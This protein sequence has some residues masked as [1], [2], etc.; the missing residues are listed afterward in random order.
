MPFITTLTPLR[1][2]QANSFT[3]PSCKHCLVKLDSEYQP[4]SVVCPRCHAVYAARDA[5]RRYRLQLLAS[6]PNGAVRKLTIFGA[7]LDP[8]FGLS[9]S[10]FET[11]LQAPTAVPPQL[12]LSALHHVL[13]GSRLWASIP[14]RYTVQS[15]QTSEMVE[16]VLQRADSVESL[17]KELKGSSTVEKVELRPDTIISNVKPMLGL[18]STVVSILNSRDFYKVKKD[19]H[20]VPSPAVDL[21]ETE[22]W[23][24]IPLAQCNSPAQGGFWMDEGAQFLFEEI[25]LTEFLDASAEAG[26]PAVAKSPSVTHI[27]HHTRNDESPLDGGLGD[28]IEDLFQ[29]LALDDWSDEDYVIKS[30]PAAPAAQTHDNN[31]G[32][33]KT[34]HSECEDADRDDE[35]DT[36]VE[37]LFKDLVLDDLS[38]DD[39]GLK[40][41]QPDYAART[42]DTP[43]GRGITDHCEG[44]HIH[45]DDEYDSLDTSFDDVELIE[46]LE[47][48]ALSAEAG[49]R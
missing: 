26:T 37:E 16:Q 46:L 32:N 40:R 1:I 6:C 47:N 7:G 11:Y 5:P 49:E 35:Y 9:A 42:N 21:E 18:K 34:N 10:S 33:E 4:G 20:V 48:L 2:L 41:E 24:L 44:E 15:C 3:F 23:E 28:N 30:D 43:L 45:P 22:S 27:S 12:V 19:E 31:L 36:G 8:I 13:C 17:V 29:D 38:D 25:S 14:S 39:N